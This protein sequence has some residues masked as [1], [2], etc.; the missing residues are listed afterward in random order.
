[1]KNIDLQYCLGTEI[2]AS[3]KMAEITAKYGLSVT[4]FF[5]GLCAKE[6]PDLLKEIGG[7]K[8]VEVGGHNSF[9][10]RPKKLFFF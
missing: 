6:S 3:R 9:A 5:T 4:L 8:N 10:F 7:I 2:D 1:M